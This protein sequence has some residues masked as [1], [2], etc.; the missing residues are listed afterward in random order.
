MET[1]HL[2]LP[3]AVCTGLPF[4]RGRLDVTQVLWV[5]AGPG[6]VD[7]T[8]RDADEQVVAQG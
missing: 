2:R 7:V 8:V 5:H 4:A 6:H 1:W 3:E